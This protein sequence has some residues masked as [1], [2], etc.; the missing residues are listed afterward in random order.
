VT[1][2][3]PVPTPEPPSARQILKSTAI[4]LAVAGV[5]LVTIVLPAEYGVDPTGIGRVL[6]L[7]EMGEIK[8]DLAAEAEAARQPVAPAPAGTRFLPDT[9]KPDVTVVTIPP[10]QAR[11]IK[12]VMVKGARVAYA[13]RTN[14]GVVNYDMHADAPGIRYHGYTKGTATPSDSGSL[15]A[16]FDG[17]HGWFWRN[18]GNDTVVV[19]LRTTGAYTEV[20]QIQ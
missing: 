16:A 11:E 2:P 17:L 19:T 3:A 15:V 12:L 18:R 1:T 14:R 10:T 8:M 9:T 7:K 5:I 4:A 20:K 13:W 6:G